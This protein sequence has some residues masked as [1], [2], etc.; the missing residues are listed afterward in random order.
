MFIILVLYPWEKIKKIRKKHKISQKELSR[1]IL[2]LSMLSYIESGQFKLKEEIAIKLVDRLNSFIKDLD[3]KINYEYILEKPLE[4][5]KKNM[6]TELKNIRN[7]NLEKLDKYRNTFKKFDS[8]YE[9]IKLF[10]I[11]GK[12][13]KITNVSTAE[14]LYEEVLEVSIDKNIHNFL[15]NIILELQR[16]YSNEGNFN[17]TLVLY[18]KVNRYLDMAPQIIGGFINYNFGLALE[19]N[20]NTNE[21]IGLYEKALLQLKKHKNLFYVKNNLSICYT[22][23]CEYDKSKTLIFDLLELDLTDIQKTKCYTN[24]IMNAVYTKDYIC[25]KITVPKLEALLNTLKNKNI[26]KYQSYYCLGKAYL[27]IE[28]RFNAMINFEK[29]L[30]LGIGENKNHFFIYQY[31]Y[32]IEQLAKIYSN[33]DKEKFKKLENYIMD[34]PKEMF[35]KDFFIKINQFF[36]RAYSYKEFSNYYDKINK[37]LYYE[38]DTKIME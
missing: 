2:S 1:S 22:S 19:T 17:K 11:L 13:L 16:L 37:K 20:K 4:Q 36:L 21:A 26:K 34:I 28:N 33:S 15:F 35:N 29:E 3:E 18:K 30:E 14:L 27:L 8:Y 38:N 23:I 7:F 32:C 6:I 9:Y 10:F 24:L 25:I 12:H 5:I 31:E